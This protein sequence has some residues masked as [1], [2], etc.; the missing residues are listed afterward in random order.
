MDPPDCLAASAQIFSPPYLFAP[1][2]GAAPRPEIDLVI[3][4]GG[5]EDTIKYGK[6]F[7][8]TT[9][10]SSAPSITGVSLIRL[11]SATHGFDQDQR[12]MS[13]EFNAPSLTRVTVSA[14]LH[15]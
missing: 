13:L 3:G 10:P 7:T 5:L 8:V 1:G 2:G 12:F 4:P 11:G 6:A 15:G 9:P 14:P